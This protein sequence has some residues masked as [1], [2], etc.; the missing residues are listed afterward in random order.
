MLSRISN[1]T[2][3]R[4][5]EVVDLKIEL[6]LWVDSIMFAFLVYSHT[7]IPIRVLSL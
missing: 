3:F 5:L 7:N 2:T 6:Q 1:R 4:Y